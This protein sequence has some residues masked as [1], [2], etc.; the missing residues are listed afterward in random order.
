MVYHSQRLLLPLKPEKI[1]LHR[2]GPTPHCCSNRKNWP[3]PS[4]TGALGREVPTPCLR[5]TL[6]QTLLAGGAQE[7]LP[8]DMKA[9]KQPLPLSGMSCDDM[10]EGNMPSPH[11]TL[12]PTAGR[13]ASLRDMKRESWPWPSQTAVTGTVGPAPPL[14]K[15]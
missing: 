13:R 5:C 7:S 15:I 4:A 11:P 8:V 10:G 9:R 2:I 6:E 1:G 3:W 14:G 12:T